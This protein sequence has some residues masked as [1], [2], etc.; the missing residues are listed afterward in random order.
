MYLV[1]PLTLSAFIHLWNPSGFPGLDQDEGHYMRRAMEVLQ[2][3]GPQELKATYFYP[4][5]HPYFGQIFLASLLSL[6]NYPN[7]IN[8][9]INSHSIE[10]LYLVPR[11]LMGIL[12][13]VDTFLVY[14]IADTRYNRK[15]AFVSATLFAVMPLSSVLREIFLDSIALPFILLSILFAVYYAKS[16]S[17]YG[18]INGSNKNILLILLSGIFLG[19][20]IF[21]KM[22]VFTMIPLISFIL[23]QKNQTSIS[24]NDS[25]TKTSNSRLKALGIWFVPVILIPMIWPGYAMSIGNLNEW[26]DGVVWQATRA[27]RPFDFEMKTV[28]LRMDPV[29]VAIGVAGLIYAVIRKDFFILLW[30]F[31]YLIFIYFVNWV[32][33]FHTIPIIA[34]FCIGGTTLLL[35]IFKKIH[36]ERLSKSVQFVVFGAIILF[37]LV[38]STLLVTQNINN[39]DYKLIAF[40][41]KNLPYKHNAVDNSSEKVTLIAP[42]GAFI[43]YWISG[44][45]FNKNFDFKWFES[46]RDYVQ[47]PIKTEKFLMITDWNMR[48]DLAGNSPKEHIKYVSQLYNNSNL[49]GVFYNNTSLPDLKKY[50]YTNILDDVSADRARQRGIEWNDGITVSGN[51]SAKVL[52]GNK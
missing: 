50:P 6:V 18:S 9:T 2:G 19:L 49:F 7:S 4:F 38:N 13:V 46:M 17:R 34:A 29:L 31:P 42:N 22:P 36:N 11:V 26:L 32:Y 20:A 25:T 35:H 23:L 33:F 15:V 41:T 8:P 44:Q 5:D 12:A 48:K 28:F 14:K 47:P 30:A 1:I 40:V 10:M 52:T 16:E 24:G 43:L 39:S 37:G 45:V 27:D 21:T 3:L 51:Y